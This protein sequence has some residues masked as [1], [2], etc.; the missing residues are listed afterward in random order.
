MSCIQSLKFAQGS[1]KTLRLCVYDENDDPVD[2][3]GATVYFCVKQNL[4]DVAT[5]IAKDS[6]TPADITILTQSGD[7]LGK[8]DIFI[9][10]SDTS[11]LPTG[12]HI[13]DVWVELVSGKRYE[14]VQA[15][16]LYLEQTVTVL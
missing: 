6:G 16:P 1:S 4:S 15:S 8:A 2:L 5:E 3:T 10:P 14:V 12:K 7:T 9:V 11:G 13:Y